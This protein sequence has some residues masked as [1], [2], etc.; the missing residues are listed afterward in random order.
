MKNTRL[1]ISLAIPILAILLSI[2]KYEYQVRSGEEWK[3]EIGGY[4]PR[5]L[6]KGHYLTYR[7]LFDL[8]EVE[9]RN[10]C[11]KLG[12]G[13]ENC[14]LCLQRET[15]KVKTMRC[16]T[17]AKLCDGMINEKFLPRLRKFYIP[18]NRG[19]SLENL[20]RSRKAEIL[21]SIH[22]SGDPNV[23]ELLIDGEPW[24]QAVQKEDAK[25]G[26]EN[27]NLQKQSQLSEPQRLTR[28]ENGFLV[29]MDGK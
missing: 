11:R 20:V 27:I 2:G 5:D 22:P 19:K 28:D 26:K 12:G 4:D 16:E 29:L 3:F 7:I 25:A 18:E 8:D 23:K 24:K 6:L 15:S 17:A 21:L 13:M 14:C 10:S 9:K 1:I